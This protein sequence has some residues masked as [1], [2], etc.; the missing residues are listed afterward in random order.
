M[1]SEKGQA[2][3]AEAKMKKEEAKEKVGQHAD[4][5]ERAMNKFQ[6]KFERKTKQEKLN[7]FQ[8]L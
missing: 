4:K 1:K 5:A 3:A 8:A 6:E 2:R 7:Q